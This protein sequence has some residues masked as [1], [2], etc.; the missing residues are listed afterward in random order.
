MTMADPTIK[1]IEALVD[2]LEGRYPIG[3]HLPNG[4]PEFGWRQFEAT[5]INIEAAAA[6]RFLLKEQRAAEAALRIGA[7]VIERLATKK[8]SNG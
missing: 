6:L 2:R 3:P 5:P 7:S 1:E 8:D 4:N